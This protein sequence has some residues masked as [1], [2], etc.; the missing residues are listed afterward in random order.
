[1]ARAELRIRFQDPHAGRG[2]FGGS[3]AEYLAAWVGE[4][5]VPAP[6]APRAI[7]AWSAWEDSRTVAGVGSGADVL[8]QAFGVNRDEP[9]FLEID[10]VGR[11][12]REI[13]P[14]RH[15]GCLSLFH[16]GRKLDTHAAAIPDALPVEEME[17]M[18]LRAGSWLESGHFEGFARE[19]NAYAEK[20]AALGLVA[21]Y[22]AEAVAAAR[23]L[24]GVLAAKGC[25]AMG[26]DVIL[27]A[28]EETADP[29][30][31]WATANSLAEI[32]RFSV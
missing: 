21:P 26:A 11:S 27:V 25:G 30:A 24:P 14:R 13:Y 12:L 3:G 4:R 6:D 16:T 20:L 8:T 2:G 28:H 17:D 1:M 7:F 18:V 9:F 31:D 19:V 23:K 10:L 22:T 32:G 5:R 29:F 15:Q